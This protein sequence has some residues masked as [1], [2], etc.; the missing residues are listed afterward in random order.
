MNKKNYLALITAFTLFSC[1]KIEDLEKLNSKQVEFEEPSD[2]DEINDRVEMF[3]S[4]ISN[5]E[6]S[7][8][9][10]TTEY[11]VHEAVWLI[12]ATLNYTFDELDKD[13]IDFMS[14]RDSILLNAENLNTLS[15]N[16]CEQFYN[17]FSN[18]IDSI[19]N[20]DSAMVGRLVD[21]EIN[22]N[23]ITME[24]IYGLSSGG[25]GSRSIGDPDFLPGESYYAYLW[26]AFNNNVTPIPNPGPDNAAQFI[27]SKLR[28]RYNILFLPV[29]SYFTSVGVWQPAGTFISPTSNY[30]SEICGVT[31]S[32]LWGTPGWDAVYKGITENTVYNY[33]YLNF[34]LN[35][36]DNRIS[37]LPPPTGKQVSHIEYKVAHAGEVLNPSNATQCL[38]Q[39]EFFSYF[40]WKFGILVIQK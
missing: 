2:P 37:Y 14:H 1:S 10:S 3:I 18:S 4:D 21:I 39:Y 32:K 16:N 25:S 13:V 33:T 24:F 6:R 12:E 28:L 35:E 38:G 7:F 40:R 29:G 26:N 23:Y 19:L 15:F 22:D 34:L 9:E 31:S 8:L 27:E 5:T 11:S 30:Y 36:A 17:K 20:I